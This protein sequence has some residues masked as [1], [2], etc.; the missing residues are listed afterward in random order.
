PRCP[1]GGLGARRRMLLCQSVVW[2][3]GLLWMATA[4][5]ASML[6]AGMGRIGFL[7]VVTQVLVSFAAGLAGPAE[8]GQVVGTVT[9]GIVLGIL[10]A[11][12][13]SSVAADAFGWRVEF[14]AAAVLMTLVTT[15]LAL[16]K[17]SL[18]PDHHPTYFELTDPLLHL[19]RPMP[20][21]RRP[22][23]FQAL[24]FA[25]LSPVWTALAVD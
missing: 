21:L 15:V 25:L 20:V 3:L 12:P 2:A 19:F 7:S 14:A 22:P 8:R 17:P 9:S 16:T 4:T 24:Q 5:H 13:L 1:R 11:R 18:Q 23:V 10:L 6:F